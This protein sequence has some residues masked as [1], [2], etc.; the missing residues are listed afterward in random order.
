[1][2]SRAPV[3]AV[4]LAATVL[5]AACGDSETASPTTTTTSDGATSTTVPLD[6]RTTVTIE[7]GTTI[8]V[9]V[10]DGEPDGGAQ[11]VSVP[12][13]E[14]VTIVV[15]ANDTDEVHVHGYDVRADVGP[16]AP[17]TIELIADIPGKFEVELESSH[18]L[19]VELTVT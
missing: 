6:S 16:G 13:G 5:L 15:T 2:T 8:S 1:M 9:T 10:V 3:V 19:I 18:V 7:D 4:L 12:S 11:R 14:Q 17:A